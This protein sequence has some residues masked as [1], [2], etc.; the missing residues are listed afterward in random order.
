MADALCFLS[1]RRM[2]CEI[3]SSFCSC[4]V[5]QAGA[6]RIVA[7][8]RPRPYDCAGLTR[9]LWPRLGAWRLPGQ[10]E[11]FTGQVAP[12]SCSESTPARWSPASGSWTKKAGVR[13]AVADG[14]SAAP[15]SGTLRRIHGTVDT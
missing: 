15:T 7:D 10:A 8:Q 1:G 6:I 11:G 12:P 9:F 2:G 13:T 14:G 4:S 5:V 3:L